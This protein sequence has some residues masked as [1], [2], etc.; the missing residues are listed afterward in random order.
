MLDPHLFTETTVLFGYEML[1]M[2][3]RTEKI[4]EPQVYEC[5]AEQVSFGLFTLVLTEFV[6]SKVVAVF[7][8]YLYKFW[9]KIT[10]ADYVKEEFYVAQ[11]MVT[12]LN[13]QTLLLMIIPFSPVAVIFGFVFL[14][15]NFKYEKWILMNFQRKPMNS[16]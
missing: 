12:L 2:R 9:Y 8:P 1:T 14:V 6:V 11:Q 5:R 7:L 13:F 4:F 3:R 10:S 16:W 15:I